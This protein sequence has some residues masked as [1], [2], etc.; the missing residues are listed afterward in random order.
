MTFE[1]QEPTPPP[2]TAYEENDGDGLC[3]WID[4]ALDTYNSLNICKL[5]DYNEQH[6]RAN[7][8]LI[9][10]A[11]EML[12]AIREFLAAQDGTYSEEDAIDALRSVLRKVDQ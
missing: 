8:R 5:N 2:W 12:S 7:A 4:A 9:C 3:I 11:P 1:L 10:A 6:M